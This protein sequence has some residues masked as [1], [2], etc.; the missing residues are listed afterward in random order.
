MQFNVHVRSRNT[1]V[2]MNDSRVFD[3]P[4]RLQSN[5]CNFNILNNV[6]SHWSILLNITGLHDKISLNQIPNRS[7]AIEIEVLNCPTCFDVQVP[8]PM[9]SYN[10]S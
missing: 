8:T 9:Y 3:N 6:Q 7:N 2:L 1:V 5:A 10:F 4:L